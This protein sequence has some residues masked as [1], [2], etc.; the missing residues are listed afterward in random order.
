MVWSDSEVGK[1]QNEAVRQKQSE[2]QREKWRRERWDGCF[3]QLDVDKRSDCFFFKWRIKWEEMKRIAD[4]NRCLIS[5]SATTP[6]G[7]QAKSSPVGRQSSTGRC[8]SWWERWWPRV[9]CSAHCGPCSG[10]GG[11]L[12]SPA[13]GWRPAR[14]GWCLVMTLETIHCWG[15][16]LGDREEGIK[17]KSLHNETK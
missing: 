17:I 9:G 3:R 13:S 15:Q 6:A 7:I 2:T 14:G 12:K 10:P 8:W 16:R 11:A 1:H 5:D 4:K